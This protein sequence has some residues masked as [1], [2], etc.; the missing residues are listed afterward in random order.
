[1][2][3]LKQSTA[4]TIPFGP[5]VDPTDGV[6]LKTTLVSAL[7]NAT[8]GIKISKNGN[9]LAVRNSGT[10]TTYDTGGYGIYNV[11]LNATDTGTLGRLFMVFAG[12][13]TCLPIWREY[14]VV[15]A[16]IYDSMTNASVFQKV[17]IAAVNTV[18]GDAPLLS[19][20]I[21][22]GLTGTVNTAVTGATSTT[23]SFSDVTEATA[24]HYVGKQGWVITGTLAKQW[25]GTVIAYSLNTGEGR[26]TFSPGSP[27]SEVP[28][29]GN[30]FMFL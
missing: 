12:N 16:N 1:M 29:T 4:V 18:A 5:F 24:S 6:T 25:W 13:A 28:V 20:Q 8:T 19:A 2:Q 7:D 14:L 23:V 9:S 21:E 27:T 3:L 30:V 11:N 10:A 26:F 17:D 15:A 22:S